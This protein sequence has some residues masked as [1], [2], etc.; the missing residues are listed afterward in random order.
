[1]EV[2]ETRRLGVDRLTATLLYASRNRMSVV[3]R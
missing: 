2:G 3:R 1:M